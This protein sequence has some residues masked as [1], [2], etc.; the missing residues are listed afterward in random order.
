MELVSPRGLCCTLVSAAPAVSDSLHLHCVLLMEQAQL[1][2]TPPSAVAVW[3]RK[4]QRVTSRG[5]SF[6]EW[7][8]GC[9][10]VHGR[11]A[12]LGRA[13]SCRGC[14]MS[15]VACAPRGPSAVSGLEE[16]LFLAGK[17]AVPLVWAR[18]GDSWDHAG[19]GNGVRRVK[20]PEVLCEELGARANPAA[21]PLPLQCFPSA[22]AVSSPQPCSS[23]SRSG[24]ASQQCHKA[25]VSTP[26][27]PSSLGLREPLKEAVPG[28]VKPHPQENF[29]ET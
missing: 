1:R 19:W 24:S 22:T 20:G 16:G 28:Q 26:H 14:G 13:H 12:V 23:T 2:V 8:L 15:P 11:V 25:Q 6:A 27:V 29:G 9:G 5:C 3:L 7:Q 10:S 21:F 4:R 17:A 18:K